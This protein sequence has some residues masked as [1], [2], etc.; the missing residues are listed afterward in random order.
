ML[1]TIFKAMSI[2]PKTTQFRPVLR[3]K[4]PNDKRVVHSSFSR[5]GPK[6]KKKE[7]DLTTDRAEDFAIATMLLNKL[8]H[9]PARKKIE[10]A[11][12][13]WPAV[14]E[15]FRA[16]SRDVKRP[17]YLIFCCSWPPVVGFAFPT[18]ARPHF[19]FHSFPNP[20]GPV[21]LFAKDFSVSRYTVTSVAHEILAMRC[22]KG[23]PCSCS[24]HFTPRYNRS[25]SAT[26]KSTQHQGWVSNIPRV[27]YMVF[28]TYV[29][30]YVTSLV[31]DTR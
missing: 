15:I 7:K 21:R 2:S 30:R 10:Q 17:S 4:K 3:S 18:L 26:V 25:S 29:T 19:L 14:V 5:S 31:C 22:R 12:V 6:E 8:K 1:S 9:A 28:Y 24:T 27:C 16:G 11:Q 20:S 13:P 23:I